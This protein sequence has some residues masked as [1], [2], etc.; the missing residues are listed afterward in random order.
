MLDAHSNG[1][2]QLGL[3]AIE[4][5]SGQMAFSRTCDHR[6]DEVP[7]F[8]LGITFGNLCRAGQV[9]AMQDALESLEYGTC[10]IFAQPFDDAITWRAFALKIAKS[11]QIGE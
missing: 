11:T 4:P 10:Q 9:F 3:Q 8:R 6:M 5:S 1:R 7:D 2:E